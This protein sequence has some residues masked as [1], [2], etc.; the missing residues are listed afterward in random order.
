MV[1][2]PVSEAQSMAVGF[3][4]ESGDLR[5][6]FDKFLLHLKQNGTYYRIVK[7]Y[8]PDIFFFFPEEFKD[9]N[10]NLK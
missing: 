10:R 4:M 1:I 9:I 8:Y 5:S 3:R 6:A 2:G 7:K